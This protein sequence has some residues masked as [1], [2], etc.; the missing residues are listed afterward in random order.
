MLHRMLAVTARDCI[1]SPMFASHNPFEQA[2]MAGKRGRAGDA[3]AS[4]SE[5]ASPQEPGGSR[6]R[7]SSAGVI[8]SGGGFLKAKGTPA[9]SSKDLAV[10]AADAER[11]KRKRE[12]VLRKAG[13]LTLMDLARIA[14]IKR[15]GAPV[16]A[17]WPPVDS[18]GH[19][20]HAFSPTKNADDPSASVAARACAASSSSPA[21]S[22][23]LETHT[24]VTLKV[25]VESP[26]SSGGDGEGVA[27]CA[28][29][30]ASE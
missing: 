13:N 23:T 19:Q 2:A 26:S 16:P 10:A 3:A 27:E 9:A 11:T 17:E 30:D 29:H 8:D 7:R 15:S 28:G 21:P 1:S 6:R 20:H 25:K 14:M 5:A 18:A 12:K 24:D 22:A 4:A